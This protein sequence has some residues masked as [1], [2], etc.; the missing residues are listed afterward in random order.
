MA[1]EAGQLKG[2]KTL[3]GKTKNRLDTNR[4]SHGRIGYA[5]G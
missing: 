5:A 4:P 1:A 2:K 3:A